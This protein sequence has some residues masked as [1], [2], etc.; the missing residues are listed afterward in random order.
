MMTIMEA[1]SSDL[2]CLAQWRG[3]KGATV[4]R[5]RASTGPQ[6]ILLKIGGGGVDPRH[7]FQIKEL[8][9]VM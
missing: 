9:P 3:D 5:S 6:Y 1:V 2:P 8:V 4:L 7:A